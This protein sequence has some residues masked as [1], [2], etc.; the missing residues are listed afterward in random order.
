MKVEIT[1]SKLNGVFVAPPSK[2]FA[3]RY[4]LASFLSGEKTCVNGTGD[5]KDVLA[6]LG[7]ICSVGAECERTADGVIIDGKNIVSEA[8]TVFCN[9]SGTT[10]RLIMPVLSALGIRTE[11]TGKPTLLSRPNDKLISVLNSHGAK[12]DGYRLDG[13]LKSGKYEIDAGISSQYISGLLFALPLLNGDSE[14]VFQGEPVSERYI[15]ITEDVLKKYRIKTEKTKSGYYVYGNQK[16]VL[17]KKV[18]VEGD[19]SSSAFFLTAGAIGGKIVAENLNSESRQGDS[20]ILKLLSDVGAK[21]ERDNDEVIV[22][23]GEIKPF[24]FDGKDAPDI[25]QIVSVLACFSGGKSVI[26]GVDRLKIKESDRLKGIIEMLVKCGI[27]YEYD[28]D[29]LTV[30]GGKPLGA[31]YGGDNDHRTV[32]S[33]TILSSY[34]FGAS[35]VS[36]AEAVDKS[37]PDFFKDYV[38]LG[39]K[40]NVLI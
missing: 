31:D 39:G 16:Y 5:S 9:E 40:A 37:Y 38:K 15:E 10:L 21:V 33:R 30:W 12:I 24:F 34:S 19:Y 1:P 11:L 23:A 3:H 32:M 28:N 36:G 6:T 26:K 13:K 25:I 4:L 18:C 2:S 14:I 27:R 17:P 22:S 29:K 7:A 20:V 35:S 8:E